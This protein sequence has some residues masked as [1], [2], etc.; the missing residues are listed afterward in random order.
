MKTET[1]RVQRPARPLPQLST[2]PS[3]EAPSANWELDAA[4]AVLQRAREE[5]EVVPAWEH[6]TEM[7]LAAQRRVQSAQQ[8]V[9][10]ICGKLA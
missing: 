1:A 7:H 4:L 3:T 10:R 6:G 5:L 8:L 9:N 2:A